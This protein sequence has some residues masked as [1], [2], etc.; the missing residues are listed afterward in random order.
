MQEYPDRIISKEEIDELKKILISQNLDYPNYTNWVKKIVDEIS[1]G[2]RYAFG[3]FSGEVLR[4]DGV[5]RVTS[6]GTVELRNFY[7]AP[8]SRKKGNGT[9]LLNYIEDY[10]VERGYSQIKVD[11]DV[12]DVNTVK[13][14]L[15][16]DFEFQS[17]A[18]FYGRGKDSYLLVKKLPLKYI[19]EYDWVTITKWVLEKLWNFR[20]EKEVETRKCYIYNKSDKGMNISATININDSFGAN[21]TEKYLQKF[22]EDG[23]AKG[24]LFC[25]GPSFTEEAEAYAEEK[26][27]TIINRNELEGLTGYVLPKSNE[28]TAGLIVSIKPEFYE[29]LKNAEDRVFIKGGPIPNTVSSGQVIVFYVTSPSMGIKGYAKIMDISSGSP[30][31][32]WEKHSRQT[33][34]SEQE[35]TT[36][37]QG[38]PIITAY[39]FDC[40]KE[41]DRTLD[42]ETVR[43]ILGKFNHQ[44]GQKITISEWEGLRNS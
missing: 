5:I 2:K 39:L 43:S 11:S 33:A 42:L 17:R 7:L 13:F 6:S 31:D 38:K 40:V 22:Y 44:A 3:L 35:Y 29:N 20:L 41:M 19:G 25:F 36:Y 26:G 32:I 21:I 9:K 37:V 23:N 28:D 30:T 34:F 15:R 1:D 14:F 18:D 12:S 27:I 16:H 24:L 10:C 4:G 8:D